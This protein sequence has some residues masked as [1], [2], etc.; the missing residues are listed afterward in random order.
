M[1]SFD[2]F[3]LAPNEIAASIAAERLRDRGNWPIDRW[4][5]QVSAKNWKIGSNNFGSRCS[6]VS[7]TYEFTRFA[8]YRA[9]FFT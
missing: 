8:Y 5:I 6:N 4:K 7:K 2:D 3:Q 1:T 9:D